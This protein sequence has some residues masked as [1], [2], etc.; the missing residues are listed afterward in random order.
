M[1]KI[2]FLIAALSATS[3]F[4]EHRFT[5]CYHNLSSTP[6]S[7]IN[8]GISHKWKSRG[9]LVG[10]GQV[11]P[12][13]TKCFAKIADETMFSTDYITFTLGKSEGDKTYTRWI[14]IANSG[15]ARPFLFAQDAVETKTGKLKDNTADGKDNYELHIFINQDGSFLYSNSKDPKDSENILTPRKFK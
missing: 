10:T 8:D 5:V 13:A 2:L 9:E 1:K 3:A 11:E 4:A 7:Y 6:V 15:F 12:G 14:G